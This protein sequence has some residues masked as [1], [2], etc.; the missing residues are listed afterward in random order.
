LSFEH[1][2]DVTPNRFRCQQFHV[3]QFC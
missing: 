1:C 3:E 2:K